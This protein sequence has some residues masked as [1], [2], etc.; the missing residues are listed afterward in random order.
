M[1]N[2][3]FIICTMLQVLLTGYFIGASVRH[4]KKEEYFL[5]GVDITLAIYCLI[6]IASF[7]VM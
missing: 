7:K 4:F 2:A 1:N 5:F 6:G 3:I